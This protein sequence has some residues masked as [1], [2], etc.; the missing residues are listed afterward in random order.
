MQI[1]IEALFLLNYTWLH[2]DLNTTCSVFKHLRNFQQMEEKGSAEV[3]K[4]F[5]LGYITVFI[6]FW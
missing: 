4:I 6:Y 1:M 5:S 2:D 3:I